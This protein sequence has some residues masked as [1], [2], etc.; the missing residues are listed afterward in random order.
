MTLP[1]FHPY[2]QR[3]A[4]TAIAHHNIPGNGEANTAL[5]Y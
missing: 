1:A 4:K 5:Y 2:E 3:F